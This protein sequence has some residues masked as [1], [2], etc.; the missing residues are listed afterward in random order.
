M[1]LNH[2]FIIDG[3]AYLISGM[4]FGIFLILS[5]LGHCPDYNHTVL[6]SSIAAPVADSIRFTG[7]R[8]KTDV[9]IVMIV[10]DVDSGVVEII[11]IVVVIVSLIRETC[12]GIIVMARIG[13][14]STTRFLLLLLLLLH[15]LCRVISIC[16]V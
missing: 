13:T 8:V 6:P 14:C 4:I 7:W 5:L 9:M 2:F 15:A 3:M 1:R 10:M 11:V 12:T 16:V